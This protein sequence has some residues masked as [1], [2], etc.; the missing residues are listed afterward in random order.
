[1]SWAECWE[2]C[3]LVMMVFHQPLPGLLDLDVDELMDLAK[4]AR[5]MFK[6]KAKAS[7]LGALG[8]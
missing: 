3:K 1:M 4:D 6:L 2:A 7:S 8:L 5:E